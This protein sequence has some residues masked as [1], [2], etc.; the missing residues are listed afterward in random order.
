MNVLC[1]Q[2]ELYFTQV[3]QASGVAMERPYPLKWYVSLFLIH[4]VQ[5]VLQGFQTMLRGALIFPDKF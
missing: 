4:Q 2:L 3:A 1:K 5:K